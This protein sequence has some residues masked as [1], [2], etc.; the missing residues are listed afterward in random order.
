MKI[1]LLDNYDSFTYNLYQYL[2]RFISDVEVYKNDELTIEQ[3]E[4]LS[5]DKIVISPGPGR[6]DNAGISLD[7][8]LRLGKE[9]PILGVCLGH[10]VIAQAYGAR[11]IKTENPTHGKSVYITHNNSGIYSSLPNL[12]KVGL[13]HS[14][15]IEQSSLTADFGVTS[16]SQGNQIMGIRHKVFNLEGVQFHPESILTEYG[17]RMIENWIY[18]K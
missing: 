14:L 8:V 7:V 3:I 11:I 13:Y 2:K 15:V 18:D 5:P 6:P 10:Q 16:R 17:Y 12:I 9:K 4:K 1:L